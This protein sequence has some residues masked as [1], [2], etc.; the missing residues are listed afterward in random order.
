MWLGGFARRRRN[1]DMMLVY[2]YI[3]SSGDAVGFAKAGIMVGSFGREEIAYI[4]LAQ[5]PNATPT[6]DTAR[7]AIKRGATRAYTLQKGVWLWLVIASSNICGMS[8]LCAD[9][10]A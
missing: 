7:V 4:I 6:L 1:G 9:G 5:Y 8:M 2:I 10:A 3:Y